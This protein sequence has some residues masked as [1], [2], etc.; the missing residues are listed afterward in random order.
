MPQTT[1]E[2]S[3]EQIQYSTR[4]DRNAAWLAM[5]FGAF[6]FLDF[7]TGH[8]GRGIVKL[9]LTISI[10]G[11]IVNWA[12]NLYDMYQISSG[13]Y[14][15]G[16]GLIIRKE[17]KDAQILFWVSA[18]WTIIVVVIEVAITVFLVSFI[19]SILTSLA[20]SAVAIQGA[21]TAVG[22]AATSVNGAASAVGGAADAVSTTVTSYESSNL[23]GNILHFIGSLFK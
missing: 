10:L 17:S 22:A 2:S 16:D 8:P 14:K 3:S 11:I 6:G 4:S 7:Y 13:R 21:A 23:I 19:G 20:G 18:A 5:L 9:L 12:W 15:D 1:S